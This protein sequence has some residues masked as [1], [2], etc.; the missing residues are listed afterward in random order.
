MFLSSSAAAWFAQED[1]STQ[2]TPHPLFLISTV[3]RI[4]TAATAAPI[5]GTAT[6]ALMPRMPP[7]EAT[8]PPATGAAIPAPACTK[9]ASV[10]AS[11]I[12][13]HWY[14]QFFDPVINFTPTKIAPPI[15]SSVIHPLLDALRPL[16]RLVRALDGP[17]IEVP[18]L[19]VVCVT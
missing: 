16:V 3:A 15:N 12:P 2:V 17:V 4:A 9:L 7:A 6:A 13:R 5:T 14:I 18:A 8:R 11:P 19:L 10:A 1:V